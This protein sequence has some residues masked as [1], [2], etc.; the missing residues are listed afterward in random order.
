MNGHLFAVDG[1]TGG[2]QLRCIDPRT[3]GPKWTQGGGF[4]NLTAAGGKLI[5]IDGGGT[6]KVIE[7]DPAGYKELAKASVLQ[8]GTKWT[9]PI[10]A[11]GAIYCRNSG[12]SLVCVDVR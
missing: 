7:A 6:L 4:E 9:A 3:G 10:L 1:N 12:G 11:N 5:T 8:G 2:G